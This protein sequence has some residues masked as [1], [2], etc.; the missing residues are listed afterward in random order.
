MRATTTKAAA[1]LAAAFLVLL[2]GCA[3][4]LQ[5]TSGTTTTTT[6]TDGG[7]DTQMGGD[8]ADSTDGVDGPTITTS[9]V[10]EATAEADLA[11]VTVSV[12]HLADTADA[13]REDVATRTDALYAALD[14]AGVGDE[15][16][17]TVSYRL[18]PE[19]DYAR[20]GGR[21]L[22][23]YRAVHTLEVEVSPDRAGEVVDLAVGEAAAEIGGVAFTLADETRAQ[24]RA[25]AVGAAVE[26]ARADADAIADAAGLSVTGVASASTVG[27]G[28]PVPYADGRA[29]AEDAGG[30]STTFQPGPVTV[31][32]TVT[33]VYTAE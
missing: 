11:L 22:L 21:T 27:V 19:Y 14:A 33:M 4:P 29:A 32:A 8:G 26:N 18:Q 30:A 28:Y 31:T 16:V 9:G 10:G 17:R 7:A 3:G 24:V 13:A 23:G 15:S 12:A 1:A 6:A 5:A 2:A 20:E 25:E